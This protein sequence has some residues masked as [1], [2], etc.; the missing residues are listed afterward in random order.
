MVGACFWGE[1]H[2]NAHLQKSEAYLKPDSSTAL[3]S[4]GTVS[5]NKNLT[6]DRRLLGLQGGG[7]VVDEKMTEKQYTRNTA[8]NAPGWCT[9]R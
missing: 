4:D 1:M 3:Q 8:Q 9:V 2:N 6:R 5:N 7:V